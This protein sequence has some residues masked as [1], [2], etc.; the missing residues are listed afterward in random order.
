MVTTNKN[1]KHD[2]LNIENITYF[3]ENNVSIF[4]R[5]GNKVF[6]RDGYDNAQ[7][8]FSGTSDD[9]I[10]LPDGTYYYVIDK[11]NGDKPLHGFIYLRR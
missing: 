10:E 7:V 2:F 6:E 5:W 4:D 1:G 8:V 9:N 11:N 3:P